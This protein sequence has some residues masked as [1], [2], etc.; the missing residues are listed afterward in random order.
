MPSARNTP[1]SIPLWD[2]PSSTLQLRGGINKRTPPKRSNGGKKHAHAS[3]IYTINLPGPFSRL[4]E[5]AHIPLTDIQAY[6]SR[7]SATRQ[8]EI[9]QPGRKRPKHCDGIP[10]PANAFLLY[11]MCY[12]LQ[13]RALCQAVTGSEQGVSVVCGASWRLE[14]D[15]VRAGFKIWADVEAE[16]HRE[17]FPDW[18]FKPEK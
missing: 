8:G 14:T 12:K 13:A 3:N 10:R 7:D 5:Y 15:D 11:R 1:R 18:R 17:A 4:T 6:V 2:K 16:K 9:Q